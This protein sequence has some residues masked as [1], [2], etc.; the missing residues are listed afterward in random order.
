M[1]MMMVKSY[2]IPQVPCLLETNCEHDSN[3]PFSNEI[4]NSIMDGTGKPRH[5]LLCGTLLFYKV[6]T[7]STPSKSVE[8]P[9]GLITNMIPVIKLAQPIYHP[10]LCQRC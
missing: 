1:A 5:L 3:P 2:L 8:Y 9:A 6:P 7:S 4:P 10:S